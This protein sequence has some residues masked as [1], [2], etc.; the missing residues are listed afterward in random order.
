MHIHFKATLYAQNVVLSIKPC[1]C[2]LPQQDPH[3]TFGMYKA[4]GKGREE[5]RAKKISSF[6]MTAFLTA[7][8][9]RFHYA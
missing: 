3:I 2:V 5:K 1:D 4:M 8:E 9:K 7:V 6:T